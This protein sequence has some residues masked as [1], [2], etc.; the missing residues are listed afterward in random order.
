MKNNQD[1]DRQP[2][3]PEKPVDIPYDGKSVTSKV[4]I[5]APKQHDDQRIRFSVKRDAE[6]EDMEI[7]ERFKPKRIIIK[8]LIL[9]KD[10]EI[11]PPVELTIEILEED[12]QRANGQPFKLA[13]SQ[14]R[15]WVVWP[16]EFPCRAGFVTV[17]LAKREDPAIAISP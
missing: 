4:K 7:T 12:V 2:L 11:D 15:N 9:H 13:Y 8:N 14:G 10:T 16:E 1:E 17:A 3:D 6:L 5:K